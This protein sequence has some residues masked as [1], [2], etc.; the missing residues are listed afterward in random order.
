MII[1]TVNAQVKICTTIYWQFSQVKWWYLTLGGFNLFWDRE[2]AFD[3]SRMVPR[4]SG[5]SVV[6]G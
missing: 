4:D 3:R 5:P 1:N 2:L 6:L